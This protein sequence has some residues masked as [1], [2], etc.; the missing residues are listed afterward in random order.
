MRTLRPPPSR[1]CPAGTGDTAVTTSKNGANSRLAALK[2][3]RTSLPLNVSGGVSW[4]V[5]TRA[6]PL[7]CARTCNGRTGSHGV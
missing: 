3:W 5:A 1:R 7:A 4:K 6:A 2:P